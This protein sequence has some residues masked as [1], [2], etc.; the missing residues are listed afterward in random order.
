V[1]IDSDMESATIPATNS[2]TNKNGSC[3]TVAFV[4]TM[5]IVLAFGLWVKNIIEHVGD[6]GPIDPVTAFF[7]RLYQ[8]DTAKKSTGGITLEKYQQIENGMSY[9]QVVAILGRDGVEHANS[10]MDGVSGVMPSVD[11]I[12]YMWQNGDGSNM[13]VTFQND[14]VVMKAQAFLK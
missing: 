8:P 4:I 12:I 11:T 5:V 3:G 6:N 14:K 9:S 13:S 10:H 1:P 2:K 7:S